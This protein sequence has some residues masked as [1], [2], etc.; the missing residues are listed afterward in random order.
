MKLKSIYTKDAV[1]RIVRKKYKKIG[2]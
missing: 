2:G 1:G